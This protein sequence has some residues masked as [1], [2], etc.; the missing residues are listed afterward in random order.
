MLWKCFRNS[1]LSRDSQNRIKSFTMTEPHSCSLCEIIVYDVAEQAKEFTST[2]RYPAIKVDPSKILENAE[3]G[4]R[5][6][7]SSESFDEYLRAKKRVIEDDSHGSST[8][9]IEGVLKRLPE[10]VFMFKGS[11]PCEDIRGVWRPGGDEA[12][13]YSEAGGLFSWDAIYALDYGSKPG[14]VL[15]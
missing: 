15:L 11:A 4:C 14:F 13:I 3:R 7:W 9:F 8:V 12:T 10:L 2:G 1:G 6:C 5:L